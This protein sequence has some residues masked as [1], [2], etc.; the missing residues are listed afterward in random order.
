MILPAFTRHNILFCFLYITFLFFLHS[1]DFRLK[2]NISKSKHKYCLVNNTIL[3]ASSGLY[4]S[5]IFYQLVIKLFKKYSL[6]NASPKNQTFFAIINRMNLNR[7]IIEPFKSRSNAVNKCLIYWINRMYV[8]GTKTIKKT[9]ENKNP[10]RKS[11]FSSICWYWPIRFFSSIFWYWPIRFLQT[12]FPRL[13]APFSVQVHY[14]PN[15]SRSRS[16]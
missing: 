7:I 15:Q 1:W 3:Q 2:F 4:S 8:H 10:N 9:H 12:E 5:T 6:N 13:L 11:Y 16:G 14:N